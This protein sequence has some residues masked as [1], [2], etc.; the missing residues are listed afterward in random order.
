LDKIERAIGLVP[1]DDGAWSYKGYLLF[2]MAKLAEIN[3]QREQQAK[4]RRQADEAW[5]QSRELK[6]QKEKRAK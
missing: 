4:Y 1:D 5:A 3:G 6:E 2:E